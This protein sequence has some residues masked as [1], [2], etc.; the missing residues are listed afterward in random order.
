MKQM[1][2]IM[3]NAGSLITQREIISSEF[4]TLSFVHTSLEIKY[5]EKEQQTS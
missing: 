5:G 2:V 1:N 3:Q 4:K